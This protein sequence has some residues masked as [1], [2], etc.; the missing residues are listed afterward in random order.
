[1]GSSSTA[2]LR[3][4]VPYPA[5]LELYL[6]KHYK[7]ENP[8]PNIRIDVFNRGKGGEEANLEVKRFKTDIFA[9]RSDA[10]A[11][12]GRDQRGVSPQ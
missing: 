8:H 5:R 12:A 6:R 1:M 11:L 4:V 9:G 7:D 3:N 10:G 2:G